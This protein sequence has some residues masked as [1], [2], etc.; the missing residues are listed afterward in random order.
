MSKRRIFILV[1]AAAF[2]TFV[3]ADSMLVWHDEPYIEV[4]HGNHVHY[5][6]K[7]CEDEEDF[8]M[9]AFPTTPPGPGEVITCD[10]Q[11]VAVEAAE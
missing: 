1:V 4:P 5:V 9:D 6:P 7:G 11:T 8:N 10:G 3:L 2:G